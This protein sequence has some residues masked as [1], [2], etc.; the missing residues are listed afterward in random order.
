M[1]N[2]VYFNKVRRNKYNAVKQHYGDSHYHSKFEASYAQDLDWR[3]KAKEIKSWERQVKLSLNVN[4]KH[5]CNYY[6]DFKIIHNDNSVE[7]IEVKGFSTDVWRLKWKLC[8]ALIDEI[9]PG[10]KLTIVK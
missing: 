7:L 4:G 6:I 1:R 5:I 3:L 8:E 10:A 9:E 2:I